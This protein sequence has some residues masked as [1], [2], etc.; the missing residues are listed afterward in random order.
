[1]LSVLHDRNKMYKYT[2]MLML[3]KINT[4]TKHTQC[5]IHNEQSNGLSVMSLF[6]FSHLFMNV[7]N[8]L[9]IPVSS[10]M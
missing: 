6:T 3:P 7:F 9:T 2:K 10:I 5:V 1:M 4:Y 8:E